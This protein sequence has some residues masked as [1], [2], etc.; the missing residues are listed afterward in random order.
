[1]RFDVRLEAKPQID[2]AWRRTVAPSLLLVVGLSWGA[3]SAYALLSDA[4]Q[5]AVFYATAGCYI[6][7]AVAFLGLQ[8]VGRL[9]WMS[10]P[11]MLTI[12]ALLGFAIMP[13]VRFVNG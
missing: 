9:N 8:G 3:W 5:T 2:R 13:T 4:S 6:L 1:M 12:E 7:L 10:A 11:S